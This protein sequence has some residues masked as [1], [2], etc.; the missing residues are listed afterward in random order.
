MEKLEIT[1]FN[2]AKLSKIFDFLLDFDLDFSSILLLFSYLLLKSNV[3]IVSRIVSI[4][5][6]ISE[7]H[8]YF[9]RLF[10]LFFRSI[11]RYSLLMYSHRIKRYILKI[12]NTSTLLLY[13]PFYC[14]S[15]LYDPILFLEQYIT[16]CIR[17][18][19]NH[20]FKTY[21]FFF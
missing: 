19:R 2:F 21:I 7:N 13:Q 6:M 8:S 12:V 14:V 5:C 20:T 4:I 9:T 15:N 17:Y 16:S 3:K 10:S 1:K 18:Y 11:Y